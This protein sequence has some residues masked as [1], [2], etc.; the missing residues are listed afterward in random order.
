MSELSPELRKRLM[1]SLGRISLFDEARGRKLLLQDLP[2]HLCGLIQHDPSTVI[3]LNA[4]V[5]EVASWGELEDGRVAIAVLVEN[6]R[7]LVA[8]T[9]VGDELQAIADELPSNHEHLAAL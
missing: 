5:K 3:D 4:I 9:E 1:A 6:A 7:A 2:K 8:G